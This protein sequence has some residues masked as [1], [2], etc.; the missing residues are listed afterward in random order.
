MISGVY[1][2]REIYSVNRLMENAV[3]AV[4]WKIK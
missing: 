4:N 1:T 2:W 3:V